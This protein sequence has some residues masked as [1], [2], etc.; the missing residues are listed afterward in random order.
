MLTPQPLLVT[1]WWNLSPRAREALQ[2]VYP[3]TLYPNRLCILSKDSYQFVFVYV[4]KNSVRLNRPN[5]NALHGF[6]SKVGMK[7]VSYFKSH[8]HVMTG[9]FFL[10]SWQ[11]ICVKEV[12]KWKMIDGVKNLH[13]YFV[14]QLLCRRIS[15]LFWGWHQAKINRSMLSYWCLGC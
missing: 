14:V 12:L 4:C 10:N 9:R 7:I 13:Q 5:Q 11:Q 6:P 1:S 2:I 8:Y 15:Q 3:C